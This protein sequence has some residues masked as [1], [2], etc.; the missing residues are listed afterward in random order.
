MCDTAEQV[1][2]EVLNNVVQHAHAEDPEGLIEL[3]TLRAGDGV[4]CSIRDNGMAMPELTL[5]LGALIELGEGPEHYP[6]R[7]FGWFL[8][9]TLTQDLDYRR[10]DGWNLLSFRISCTL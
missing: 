10:I 9:H 1:L 6:E 4:I 2:A 7:G 5:P 8:I 3:E